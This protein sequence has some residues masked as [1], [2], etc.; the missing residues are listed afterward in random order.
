MIYIKIV[1]IESSL[2]KSGLSLF[3]NVERSEDS[4][5]GLVGFFSRFFRGRYLMLKFDFFLRLDFW[6][7]KVQFLSFLKMKANSTIEK[8][9]CKGHKN[10]IHFKFRKQNLIFRFSSESKSLPSDPVFSNWVNSI[11]KITNHKLF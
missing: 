3:K 4:Y 11:A 2:T 6:F 5:I 10:V 9:K 8:Q 1:T 7:Y